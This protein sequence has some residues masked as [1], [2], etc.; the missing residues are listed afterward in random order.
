MGPE[1]RTAM[2]ATGLAG[3]VLVLL[4][5]LVT[6]GDGAV[7]AATG[8]GMVL[9]FFGLGAAVV[10]A[11]AGISPAA[12][13]LVALLTYVLQVLAVGLLFTALRGTDGPLAVV[14]PDWVAGSVIVATVVWLVTHIVAATRSRQPIYDLPDTAGDG[15]GASAS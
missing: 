8:A 14:H 5:W 3:A 6:G 9:T 7:G 4:A 15:P 11:V 10:N 13:L 12:S 2:I 1:L